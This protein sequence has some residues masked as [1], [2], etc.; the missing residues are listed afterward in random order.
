VKHIESHFSHR[1]CVH[2]PTHTRMLAYMYIIHTH[3][4]TDTLMSRMRSVLLRE[5][6]WFD[7]TYEIRITME[8][9]PTR[10]DTFRVSC[11]FGFGNSRIVVYYAE[12]REK[13]SLAFFTLSEQ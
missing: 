5:I 4:N 1:S 2:T 11:G 9:L 13:S 10:F 6:V 7:V 12:F 3:T 8:I